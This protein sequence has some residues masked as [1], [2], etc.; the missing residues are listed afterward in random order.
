MATMANPEFLAD[1][2]RLKRDV[3]AKDGDE[4]GAL[5]QKVYAAP[6]ELIERMKQVLRR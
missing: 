2:Q 1:V 5:I 6:K 3:N 4:V